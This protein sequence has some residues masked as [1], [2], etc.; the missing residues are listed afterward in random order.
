LAKRFPETLSLIEGDAMEYPLAGFSPK[1]GKDFKIVAN[2]PYNVATE[3][4][5]RL[6][7]VGERWSVMVLMFQKEVARRMTARVGDSDYGVLSL[8]CQLHVDA[9]IVMNL[10]PGAFVPPPRVHSAVVRFRPLPGTRI[11]NEEVRERFKRI[12]KGAFQARRKTFPNAV[13]G[14]G[15]DRERVREALEEL[16]LDIKVRPEGVSFEQYVALA[17]RF[18]EL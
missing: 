13:K 7:E 11:E 10:P 4:F 17:E 5:F 6:A 15:L 9:E 18:D 14:L 8:M 16:G 3:I 12:V 2:L 1:E